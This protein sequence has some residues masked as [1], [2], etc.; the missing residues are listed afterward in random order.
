MIRS[1]MHA[2]GG[3]LLEKILD[4]DDGLYQGKSIKCDNGHWYRFL[5]FREK[6]LVSVLGPIK[7][8][9]A[10]YY[11]EKTKNGFCPKDNRLDVAGTSFTPGVRRIMGRVGAYRPF[12]LGH[13]DIREISGICV[14]AKEIERCSNRLGFDKRHSPKP[15]MIWPPFRPEAPQPM[16]LASTIATL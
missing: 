14:G 16:R 7:I 13:E 15:P 4:L 5:D 2:I 10:Y 3:M 12:G 6:K 11:D 8:R 1:G 9:R